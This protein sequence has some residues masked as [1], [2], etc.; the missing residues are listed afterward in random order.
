[1]IDDPNADSPTELGSLLDAIEAEGGEGTSSA[2]PASPETPPA[3][4]EPPAKVA[5]P[6]TPPA[7]TTELKP[8][9]GAATPPAG[10]TQSPYPKELEPFKTLFEGK[11]WDPTKP[12]W[13]AEALKTLQEQEQFQGRLTTDLGLTRVESAELSQ[14]ILGT[15]TDINA[16]RSRHGLPALPFESTSIDD[17]IKA[18]GEEYALWEQAL[19]QD[20]KVS[21]AAIRTITQKLQDRKDDLRA[22]KLAAAKA[23]QSPARGSNAS[24]ENWARIT[25]QDPDANKVMSALVPFLKSKFGNGILGSFGMDI[26]NVMST[27]ERAKQIHDLAQRVYR[28]DP[29]VFEA[30]VAKRVK[31][32]MEQNRQ[33]QV[34]GGIPGGMPASQN[35]GTASDAEEHLAGMFQR[36]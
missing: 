19:S 2:P 28:G 11:K 3:G 4:Q 32:E 13:Q 14:A 12:E 18:V 25:A 17:K 33:R 31:A 7:G 20:E 29:Q 9:E 23:P 21:A 16:Y 24:G 36:G 22:E 30:E 10:S 27:P 35:N 1:M 15:P 26:Q 34:A 6:S 8:K 5:E